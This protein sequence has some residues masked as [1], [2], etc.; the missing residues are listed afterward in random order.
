M[1][2]SQLQH[3][4]DQ[5]EITPPQLILSPA[6]AARLTTA[7][8]ETHSLLD[9]LS[10]LTND[11]LPRALS[12]LRYTMKKKAPKSCKQKLSQPGS[13]PWTRDVQ[14]PLLEQDVSDKLPPVARRQRSGVKSRRR[15]GGAGLYRR[16]GGDVRRG[17][18]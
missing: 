8:T 17:A 14:T 10:S 3:Q 15:E 12:K 18:A 13:T 6:A 11:L 1:T 7:I 16:L 2:T 4:E 5:S 9:R